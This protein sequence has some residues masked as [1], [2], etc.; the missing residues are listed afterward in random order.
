MNTV[1]PTPAPPKRPIFP[2]RAYGASRSTTL[3]P[4]T[5]TSADVAC[6]TNKGAS[7]W[8]GAFLLCLI[9]P[10]SSIGSPVTF[11]IRPRVPGPTGIMMGEPVSVAVAPR[12][13]P[14]VPI[15]S[16]REFRE[17]TLISSESQEPYRPWQSCV[18][19]FHPNVAV[20]F[21]Q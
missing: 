15:S 4:V 14:S 11:M 6:S 9:G 21:N 13:R 3:I 5:R 20:L 16:T 12:T 19:H 18:R 7:A 17:A 10:R 2:P 1:L 8:M